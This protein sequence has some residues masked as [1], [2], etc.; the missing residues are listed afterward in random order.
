MDM[1]YQS[2]PGA[3]PFSAKS[4][5]S[6][7]HSISFGNL[8]YGIWKRKILILSVF[9]IA[10]AGVVLWL[11]VAERRYTPELRILI[12][13]A[14]NPFTQPQSSTNQRNSVDK[15]EV[16]SQVQVLL[17]SDLAQSVGKFG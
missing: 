6:A 11:S 5:Y 2:N 9:A 8:F 17:S 1:Y 15:N 10:V 4:G 16:T 13:S 12:E 3:Q 7:E 14:E